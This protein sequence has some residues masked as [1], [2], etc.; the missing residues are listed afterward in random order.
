MDTENQIW[1]NVIHKN[2][3]D[4]LVSHL[5]PDNILK[6]FKYERKEHTSIVR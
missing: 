5:A 1:R 2:D 4:V 3:Q 6:E